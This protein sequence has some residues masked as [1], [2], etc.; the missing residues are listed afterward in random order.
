LVNAFLS[1]IGHIRERWWQFKKMTTIMDFKEFVERQNTKFVK[2]FEL[3]NNN[4]G[5]WA[6]F[7]NRVKE[8][9][10]PLINELKENFKFEYFYL[11]T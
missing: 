5:Q 1:R 4:R 3:I 7:E 2:G 11:H 9:Y 10:Q 8:T 6:D